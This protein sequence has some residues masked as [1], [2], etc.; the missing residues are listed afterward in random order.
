MII[1][2][3]GFLSDAS[4][5]ILKDGE[6]VA[7]VSE[8]RLNRIKLWH[9][10]P[11]QSIDCVLAM[12]GLTLDDVDVI[13]TH[14]ATDTPFDEA[15]FIQKAKDIQASA[16]SQTV[17]DSQ[18]S[19]LMERMR[20]EQRVA[21]VRT[22]GYLDELKR[23]GKPMD[24]YPHHLAHAACA[25]FGS[26]WNDA[27]VLT[28]DGW[29]E[30]ASSALW[31]GSGHNL[32]RLAYSYTFDSLGYFY[33]SI[34][35]SLGFIPHRH[36]GKVLGLAAYCRDPQS[37]EQ[38]SKMVDVLPA[39]GRFV[40]RME[41]G[42][43]QPRYD[44]APIA[45]YIAG[46]SREDVAAAAQKRLEEVVCALISSQGEKARRLAV[47]GGIFAN[48][49]LNQR[50]AELPNVDKVFVYP[51]MGDGGLS[52]GSSYLSYAKRCSRAPLPVSSMF[53]G[54][55]I[56]EEEILQAIGGSGFSFKRHPN[57]AETIAALLAEG[58]VVIRCVGRMEF[59]P[60]ALGHR[61][62]LYR[63][64]DPSVNDWLN[65]RLHRSE[66]MP[67]AP[68]TLVD[69][70]AECYLNLESGRNPARFMAMTFDCTQRMRNESP[71]AVHIDGTA[72]P[73]IVTSQDYPDFHAI[74]A[75]YKRKT[76]CASLVNTSF[77]MHE[78]P[79]V[80][81]AEDAIRAF[82]AS[83]LPYMALGDFLIEQTDAA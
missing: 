14:G 40:G 83:G 59:G 11:H 56:C 22:P 71:A 25:F 48:V 20:H 67:F 18:C 81:T 35:K 2:G 36:E 27:L 1:L 77:N 37:Y 42:F 29:G 47:A 7:A 69:D 58:H 57:I 24:I 70:A 73:Q 32:S 50:I 44:N 17:K 34:T 82:A 41:N 74:L 38:I 52:I 28:A 45:G 23:L 68:A 62:I 31:V 80:N 33:G 75:A 64:S 76:G 61:S 39:E 51:N 72:R 49:K 6:V 43:Y 4:A 9:G 12:A 15:P 26:G 3:I 30:D 13:A 79:I 60:R 19:V 5:C 54:P 8:E 65:K 66:F 63:A 16:L 55:D 78:E 10:V 46:Y 53:L 21:E